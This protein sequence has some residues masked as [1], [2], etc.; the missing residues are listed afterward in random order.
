M[1]GD[2]QFP[3]PSASAALIS[4]HHFSPGADLQPSAAGQFS[5]TGQ[6]SSPPLLS[7]VSQ[8]SFNMASL[9][10]QLPPPPP[11]RNIQVPLP[12]PSFMPLKPA[13]AI[14][15]KYPRY[16]CEEKIGELATKLARMKYLGKNILSQSTYSGAADKHPLDPVKLIEMKHAKKLIS[17]WITYRFWGSGQMC[18]Q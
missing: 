18:S 9:Q 3:Q 5:S 13:Q 16:L 6:I 1:R 7:P 12:A 15:Y 2:F 14:I 8:P 11:Q 4:P 17:Q 10:P